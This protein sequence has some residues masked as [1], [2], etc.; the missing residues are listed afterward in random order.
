[1]RKLIMLGLMAAVA[2]PGVAGAQSRGEVRRDVRDLREERQELRHAVRHGDRGDIRRERR[3][4]RDARQEL[5]EDRRDWRR[6][7]WRDY[8]THNR[9]QF[10]RG[11]WHAPFRYHTFRPGLRISTSYY[12]SRYFLAD[13]WRYHLPRTRPYERW[14]RHYDD[15]LLV[16]VRRGIVVDVIRGFYW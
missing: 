13:P 2:I 12:N 4:V 10:R 3:D 11:T 16:D 14:V 6:N 1:M 8:R 5:R 9:G 15:L 7:D